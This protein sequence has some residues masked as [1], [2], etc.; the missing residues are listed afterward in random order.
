V[1]PSVRWRVL[2]GGYAVFFGQ[3]FFAI[4][5]LI[6]LPFV[7][8]TDPL[9]GL[10]LALA[11]RTAPGRLVR[12]SRTDAAQLE[13]RVIRYEYSFRLSD[14]R[15]L[16]GVSF[17]DRTWPGLT[18]RDTEYPPDRGPAVP[19]EY[20]PYDPNI[21]RIRGMRTSPFSVWTLAISLLFP[22]IGAAIAVSGI[23]TNLR[24][25]HL[26]VSGVPA[27][28]NIL[29]CRLTDV[30]Q[31]KEQSLT[32][33]RQ[34]WRA[35]HAGLTARGVGPFWYWM[36][37][38]GFFLYGVYVC[39]GFGWIVLLAM[40]VA[41]VFGNTPFL[42][43]GRPVDRVKALEF[44]AFL[45]IAWSGL[46]LLFLP[47]ARRGLRVL[48]GR[49]PLSTLGPHPPLECTFAF[50]TVEGESVGAH[51]R[52]SAPDRLGEG[53]D[54]PVLYDRQR[55]EWATLPAGLSPPIRP[56]PEGGWEAEGPG[57]FQRTALVALCG[58]GAPLA[59]TAFWAL[60]CR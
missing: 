30:S 37:F 6:T 31:A 5:I 45:L 28:A 17:S 59:A 60:F 24:R 23:R 43:N 55:P 13:R 53:A 11:R 3:V 26:L 12:V 2:I 47:R 18:S 39:F 48:R 54:E 32:E 35:R 19:I 25:I 36:G 21:S 14:G 38:E 51:E 27:R 22:A 56:S 40:L 50:R 58:L 52:V 10:R 4:A 44:I 8:S 29:A 15:T 33:I 57:T 16:H 41:E 49:A 42:L 1:P 9:G 20:D 46:A 34:R 7:L